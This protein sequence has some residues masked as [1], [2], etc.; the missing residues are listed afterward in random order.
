MKRMAKIFGCLVLGVLFCWTTG[1]DSG[2]SDGSVEVTLSEYNEIQVGMSLDQVEAIIGGGP[3]RS[4][5]AT[6]PYA[7]TGTAYQWVNLDGSAALIT[8]EDDR[9]VLKSQVNLK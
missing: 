7:N 6:G 4:A 2:D 8:F 9:V 3:T 5:S 1:C